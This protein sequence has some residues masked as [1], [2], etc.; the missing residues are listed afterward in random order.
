MWDLL[1]SEVEKWSSRVDES[2][3]DGI[4]HELEHVGEELFSSL[5]AL[6]QQS[7]FAPGQSV[8]S[9]HEV[10]FRCLPGLL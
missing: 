3:G 9:L 6:L 5:D 2:H 4:S 7:A 1:D 10:Q 8:Q